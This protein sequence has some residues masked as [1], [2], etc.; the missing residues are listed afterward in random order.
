[1]GDVFTSSLF[2]LNHYYFTVKEGLRAHRDDYLCVLE[3]PPFHLN[4]EDSKRMTEM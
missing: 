2:R 3:A 1:M 4:Y